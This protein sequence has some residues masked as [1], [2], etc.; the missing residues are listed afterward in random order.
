MPKKSRKCL[1]KVLHQLYDPDSPIYDFYPEDFGQ[2]M[3]DKQNEWEAV[4]CIPFIDEKR[5]LDAV[6]VKYN[7]LTPDESRRNSTMPHYAYHRGVDIRDLASPSIK[8]TDVFPRIQS[9]ATRVDVNAKGFVLPEKDLLLGRLLPENFLKLHRRGFP[10]LRLAEYEASFQ[11]AGVKVFNRN[12]MN[13]SCVLKIGHP[14]L[15]GKPATVN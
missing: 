2:D 9:R 10:S 14:K 5:L 1:P 3:N 12:S 11:E 13:R 6:R 7:G 15:D 4:V 8:H